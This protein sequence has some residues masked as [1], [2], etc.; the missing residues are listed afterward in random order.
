MPDTVHD[1]IRSQRFV[2]V[3]EHDAERLVAEITDEQAELRVQ[4]PGTAPG[5]SCAAVVFAHPGDLTMEPTVGLELW[6]DGNSVAGC[7]AWRDHLG[8][9]QTDVHLDGVSIPPSDPEGR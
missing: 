4:L 3:D 2:L 5:H 9:W 1:E 8:H 6:V 7:S